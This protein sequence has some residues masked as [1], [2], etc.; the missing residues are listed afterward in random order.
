MEKLKAYK[1]I[2]LITLIVL[3]FA[4]YWYE[5]RPYM[6][7]KNCANPLNFFQ[8]KFSTDDYQACL[9]KNGL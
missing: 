7:K 5:F 1:Y 2:I 8:W 9:H 4:F 3:G 6:V